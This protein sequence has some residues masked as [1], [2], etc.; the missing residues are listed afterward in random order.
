MAPFNDKYE[1]T[2]NLAHNLRQRLEDTKVYVGTKQ[3]EYEYKHRECIKEIHA[4]DTY[5]NDL[6]G[7]TKEESEYI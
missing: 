2:V 1:E 3:T 4:I 6:F 7:L 5:V